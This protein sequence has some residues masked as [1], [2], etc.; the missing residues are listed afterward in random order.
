MIVGQGTTRLGAAGWLERGQVDTLNWDMFITA[1][2]SQSFAFTNPIRYTQFVAFYPMQDRNTDVV[3]FDGLTAYIGVQV[4]VLVALVF[5]HVVMIS[6][7]KVS[8]WEECP[9][10]KC[11][12][13]NQQFHVNYTVCF[14]LFAICAIVTRLRKL[15]GP[16]FIFDSRPFSNCVQSSYGAT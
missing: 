5:V 1:E 6:S 3:R 15:Y 13:S 8:S 14:I 9:V 11:P 4:Y 10:C 2:R 16:I 12:H 7:F